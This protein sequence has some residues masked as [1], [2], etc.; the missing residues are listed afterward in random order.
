MGFET[1]ENRG[2]RYAHTHTHTHTHTMFSHMNE[3]QSQNLIPSPQNQSCNYDYETDACNLTLNDVKCQK[4][5][6]YGRLSGS[7]DVI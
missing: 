6:K 3:G 7:M 5:N 2:S 1:R 4:K